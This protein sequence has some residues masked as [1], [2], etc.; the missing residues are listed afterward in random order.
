MIMII[1]QPSSLPSQLFNPGVPVALVYSNV[2]S[3]LSVSH[4]LGNFLQMRLVFSRS[5]SN[6]QRGST[7][8]NDKLF[9]YMKLHK[10]V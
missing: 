3:V 4:E 10:I 7:A 1:N 2:L 5:I 9:W 6:S 8:G